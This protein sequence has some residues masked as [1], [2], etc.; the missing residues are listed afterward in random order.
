MNRR[1]IAAA[2]GESYRTGSVFCTRCA[3]RAGP[4]ARHSMLFLGTQCYGGS[5]L[6][7]DIPG[8]CDPGDNILQESALAARLRHSRFVKLLSQSIRT[9]A[10]SD[11]LKARRFGAQQRPRRGDVVGSH[12]RKACASEAE[13]SPRDPF[14]IRGWSSFNGVRTFHE[15]ADNRQNPEHKAQVHRVDG[16][17][18]QSWDPFGSPRNEQ[19]Q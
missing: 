11:F 16:T 10:Q 19:N 1:S 17:N 3:F 12:F 13:R 4:R 18:Y 14:L 8:S 2:I 7:T 15:P 9:F 5:P 6:R